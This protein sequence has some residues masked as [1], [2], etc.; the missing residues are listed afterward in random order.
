MS[1]DQYKTV[2]GS[3]IQYPTPPPEVA[4]FIDRCTEATEDPRVSEDALL[5]LIYGQE[6]P[7][8]EQGKFQG[9]G[10]VTKE[11]LQNPLYRVFLDLIDHKRIALGKVSPA[12]LDAA[13]T[14]T[15]AE[16]A[17]R[18]GR[19]AD[20]IRKAVQSRRIAAL[21]K[22]NGYLLDPNSVDAYIA[23][24]KP[25]GRAGT[26]KAAAPALRVRFGNGPGKSFRIKVLGGDIVKGDRR[27]EDDCKIQEATVAKFERAA[28]SISGPQMHRVFILEPTV[29]A[30]NP[31]FDFKPWGISGRYKVVEK[32]NDPKRASEAFKKFD[33]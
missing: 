27:H 5:E 15:V 1:K 8:L 28:I 18:V 30:E 13:F 9:R 10:A 33:H 25:R 11:V 12:K 4:A 3:V 2:L 7:V 16:A 24:T 19:S 6:N 31:G 26:G 32:I 14:E 17:K 23:S 29:R 22:P 21:E 20:A